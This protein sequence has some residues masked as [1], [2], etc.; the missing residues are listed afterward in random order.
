[1]GLEQLGTGQTPLTSCS[2][3]DLHMISPCESVWA[4]SQHGSSLPHS[5]VAV[6]PITGW[7]V[8]PSAIIPASK[9]EAVSSSKTSPW[10]SSSFTSAIVTKLP[11]FREKEH[12]PYVSMGECQSHTV[13]CSCGTDDTVTAIVGKYSLRHQSYFLLFL[14]LNLRQAFCFFACSCQLV[15][16]SGCPSLLSSAFG[17]QLE[18]HLLKFP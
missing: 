5:M 17:P 6:R 9:V 7:L 10:K 13:I 14:Q 15:A 8:A 12:R 3:R 4:S 18:S 2:L 1:M 11:S 16:Y